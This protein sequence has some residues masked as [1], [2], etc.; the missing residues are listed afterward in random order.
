MS[1][2]IARTPFESDHVGYAAPYVVDCEDA[3]TKRKATHECS[4][5]EDLR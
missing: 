2:R 1:D 3:T 5:D 4:D